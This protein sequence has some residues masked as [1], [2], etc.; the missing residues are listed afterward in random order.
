MNSSTGT[1]TP[2][3]T[4]HKAKGLSWIDVKELRVEVDAR[5]SSGRLKWLSTISITLGEMT[6]ARRVLGG[7]YDNKAAVRECRNNLKKFE[8]LMDGLT[9]EHLESLF[10]I[11]YPA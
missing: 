11:A 6:I 10:K 5:R 7:R 8:I 9:H 4:I 3:S 1:S 2:L